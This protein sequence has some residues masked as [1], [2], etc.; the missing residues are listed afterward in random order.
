MTKQEIEFATWCA[1]NNPLKFYESNMW[2]STRRAVLKM[3]KYACQLCK[4]KYHRSRKATTV[5]HV[6]HFKDRPDLALE[7]WYVD[8]AT[9]ERKRNLISLCHECHD[10][11][12]DWRRV[13]RQDA[14]PLTIERWD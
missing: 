2:H 6:N 3:D 5:H 12:H 7:P 11:V 9:G 14:D 8:R 13:N 1:N 10:E 4:E